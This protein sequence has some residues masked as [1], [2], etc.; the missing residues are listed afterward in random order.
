MKLTSLL[1]LAA[2]FVLGCGD[3]DIA[4]GNAC[5][6]PAT[7][8]IFDEIEGCGIMFQLEDGSFL[9]P[10]IIG[11]CGNNLPD[12]YQAP[13]IF[14]FELNEG[15]HV[16]IDYKVLPTFAPVCMNGTLVDV[17]CMTKEDEQ[18]VVVD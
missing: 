7:V 17:T 9:Q 4:P 1:F 16:T 2:L 8:R 14:N 3:D 11:Q 18:I 5:S 12:D 15:M 13:P 6:T 10:L